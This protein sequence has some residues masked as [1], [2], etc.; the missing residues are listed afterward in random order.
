[1]S[2]ITSNDEMITK[3]MKITQEKEDVTLLNNTYFCIF[4]EGRTNIMKNLQC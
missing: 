2:H 1:M 4:L 3:K